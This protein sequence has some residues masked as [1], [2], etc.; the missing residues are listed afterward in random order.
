MGSSVIDFGGV[1]FVVFAGTG[2]VDSSVVDS[3]VDN[4]VVVGSAV[5][6]GELG[7]CVV[8][9]FCI[10]LCVVAVVMRAAGVEGLLSQNTHDCLQ[11]IFMHTRLTSHSPASAKLTH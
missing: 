5:V 7:I 2:A 6:D 9:G 4:G 8:D 1:A 11:W 3:A 10:G